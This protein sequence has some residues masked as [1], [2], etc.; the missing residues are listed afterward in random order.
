[1]AVT[2]QLVGGVQECRNLFAPDVTCHTPRAAI[3]GLDEL[4]A[5]CD[6]G[7]DAFSDARVSF[8]DVK[9]TGDRA[10]V[11]WRLDAVLSG[12]LLVEDDVLLE[13][14]GE[15]V[16]LDGATFVEFRGGQIADIRHY[17]DDGQVVGQVQ[18]RPRSFG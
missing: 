1:M 5:L 6:Q 2:A 9:V 8:R 14:N 3:H 18:S 16:H 11:E 17:F 15:A 7:E 13:P 4:A 10:C 12:P